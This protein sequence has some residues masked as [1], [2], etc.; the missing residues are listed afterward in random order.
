MPAQDARNSKDDTAAGVCAATILHRLPQP[1]LTL[2][3]HYL[4]LPDKLTQLTR[5]HRSFPPLLNASFSFDCL[6]LTPSLLATWRSSPYLRYLL[7]NVG[8]V[9]CQQ[10]FDGIDLIEMLWQVA[11]HV[12]R[13]AKQRHSSSPSAS[14]LTSASST[15]R[16]LS[17]P[18]A[19]RMVL[20]LQTHRQVSPK[21]QATA[22]SALF[23]GRGTAALTRYSR[24]HSLR[25]ELPADCA[26]ICFDH[27]C[28]SQHSLLCARCRI[29]AA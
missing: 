16:L 23:D 7:S 2:V 28:S 4:P 8:A 25:L 10:W 15:P 26:T 3:Q 11:P 1:L 21:R 22:M 5:I 20:S 24:L 17:F 14:A 19:Q 9:L 12:A 29:C 18:L 6:T 27:L 13:E